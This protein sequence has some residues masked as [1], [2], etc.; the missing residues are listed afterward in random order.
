MLLRIIILKGTQMRQSKEE[1]QSACMLP[2]LA[3]ISIIE[4]QTIRGVLRKS[5]AIESV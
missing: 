5:E 2:T 3:M 1:R 4:F